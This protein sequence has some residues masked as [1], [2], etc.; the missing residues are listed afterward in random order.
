[1]KLQDPEYKSKIKTA[2]FDLRFLLERGYRKKSA[3]NFVANRYLLNMMQRNHLVRTV[4]SR[5]ES[6]KRREKLIDIHQVG[7]RTLF[8]DGY[9]VLITVESIYKDRRSI[10]ACDDGVLRDVN[11][12]FGK[13]RI[14]KW[15]EAALNHIISILK[16]YKPY[17]VKFIYDSPVSRSGELAKLTNKIIRGYE[18]KGCAFTSRNTDFELVK[19]SNEVDGIV[20]TSDSAVM[21]KVEKILDLPSKLCELES[22]I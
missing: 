20:A 21:D 4:F 3:V 17:C 11:A 1:M 22:K 13:Y 14:N 7:G 19:L 6:I 16:P 8:V 9:N 2:A 10:V 15:T 12:V 5:K 18:I